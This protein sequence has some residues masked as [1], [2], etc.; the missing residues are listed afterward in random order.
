MR[1]I[2]SVLLLCCAS[3]L[4]CLRGDLDHN[5]RVDFADLQILM[6]EWMQTEECMANKLVVIT[7]PTNSW[8]GYYELQEELHEG[9]P[10]WKQEAEN[11][12]ISVNAT[13][14]TY[15]LSGGIGVWNI[16]GGYAADGLDYIGVYT[17]A[18]FGFQGG[19]ATVTEYIEA[20][21][22]MISFYEIESMWGF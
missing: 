3:C 14:N 9:Y 2:L 7:E 15:V 1:W 12:Y 22:E 20:G 18:G 21:G 13:R 16:A 6:S 4:G 17:G 11:H 19:T 8:T 5:G 10:V